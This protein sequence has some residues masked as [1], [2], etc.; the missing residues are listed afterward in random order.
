MVA[1]M[2]RLWHAAANF[3]SKISMEH[4]NFPAFSNDGRSTDAD[5]LIRSGDIYATAAVLDTK[6]DEVRLTRLNTSAVEN[7]WRAALESDAETRELVSYVSDSDRLV[8]VDLLP[9]QRGQR[10]LE[11]GPG[12]GQM[13]VALARQVSTVDCIEI[14]V[15]QARFCATRCQQEGAD[16]VR[17]VA[18]GHDSHLPYADGSF[19][20]VVM[21]LVFEWCGMRADGLTHEQVQR[22]YLSEI[23]RVLKPGGFLY[24]STKNRYALRLITGGRDEHM[25]QLRFGSALPRAI[26]RLFH[27]RG[28]QAGY[29]HSYGGLQAML[30][31]AGFQ[32]ITGYWATPDMRWPTQFI[33][34]D[35]RALASARAGDSFAAASRSIVARMT[36]RLP[37]PMLR[38]MTPGLTFI[39]VK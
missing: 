20:G 2:T 19:D 29:L 15:G 27:G 33:E 22:R 21:N 3:L 1:A 36:R 9:L 6:I 11:I 8:V 32:K 7:G 31:R 5:T 14:S 18:G 13:T 28:R 34:L 24:L 30:R 37:L 25:A 10:I 39:A 26:G 12:Y 23:A 16:N 38:R 4:K 35:P 17:V